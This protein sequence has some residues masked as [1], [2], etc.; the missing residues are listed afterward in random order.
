MMLNR[1]GLRTLAALSIC[2]AGSGAGLAADAPASAPTPRLADICS[3]CAIVESVQSQK[4]KG[5]G[6][7]LGK[8]GRAVVGG[9]IGHQFGGGTGKTLATVGGA[10]AGG[11]AGN[12]VQ[13]QTS[14]ATV[15]VT[16]V[17]MKDGTKRSFETKADP[18]FKPGAVVQVEGS[19]LKR[20]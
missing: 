9:V 3:K 14:A 20:P 13:K 18:G 5:E 12:E 8:V 6:G 19:T 11:V 1:A 16:R 2:G 17:S 7:L 15:W 4:R 10:V